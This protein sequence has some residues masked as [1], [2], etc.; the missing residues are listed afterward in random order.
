MPMHA[1]FLSLHHHLHQMVANCL[2]LPVKW[3][4]H[5][6]KTAEAS[7]NHLKGTTRQIATAWWKQWFKKQELCNLLPMPRNS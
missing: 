4:Q 1:R 2:L 5:S 3:L 6:N 7:G